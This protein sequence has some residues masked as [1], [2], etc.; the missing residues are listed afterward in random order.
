MYVCICIWGMPARL[1]PKSFCYAVAITSIFLRE[2]V[3]C[4]RR[5]HLNAASRRVAIILLNSTMRNNNNNSNNYSCIACLYNSWCCCSPTTSLSFS[6]CLCVAPSRSL[7][8]CR[9]LALSLSGRSARFLAALVRSA[10][11]ACFQ[12]RFQLRRVR[13]QLQQQQPTERIGSA[14]SRATYK[15]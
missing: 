5:L 7:S 6:L 3:R 13:Q 14:S 4:L 10:R 8:R 11:L 12:F 2:E 9:S 1:F 15:K